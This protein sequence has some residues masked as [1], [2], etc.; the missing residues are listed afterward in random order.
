M[1]LRWKHHKFLFWVSAVI[2]IG[3]PLSGLTWFIA[4]FDL[5]FIH[6]GHSNLVRVLAV[7]YWIVSGFFVFGFKIND[8]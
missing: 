5:P 2:T 1:K 3:C 4:K 6:G 8:E 7:V